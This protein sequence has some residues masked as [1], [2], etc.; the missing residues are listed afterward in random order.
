MRECADTTAETE[1]LYVLDIFPEHLGAASAL[2]LHLMGYR[3]LANLAELTHSQL[4][5]LPFFGKKRADIVKWVLESYGYSLKKRSRM[6]LFD[7]MDFN[8]SKDLH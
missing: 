3:T 4:S 5:H 1:P 2:M 6:G 8:A 7:V